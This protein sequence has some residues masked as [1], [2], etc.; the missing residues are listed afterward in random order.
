MKKLFKIIVINIIIFIIIFSIIEFI[1]FMSAS[2]NLN[3]CNLTYNFP[4]QK[5][6]YN[7]NMIPADKA[8]E[9]EFDKHAFRNPVG[10]EYKKKPV[11]LFGCSL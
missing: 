5:L 2:D 11:F 10:L 1:I 8:M 9:D 3:N 4:K 6:K 7:I